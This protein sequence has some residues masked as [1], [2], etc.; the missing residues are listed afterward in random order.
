MILLAPRQRRSSMSTAYECDVLIAGAGPAGLATALR[1]LRLRPHLA[2]RIVALERR[3]H[4]RPKVCAGGLI[5]RAMLA[6]DELG[7]RLDVPA[8]EVR[9]GVARTPSG[10]FA[11][12]RPDA[13][14]TIVRREEF[15]AQ[16]AQ[17]A[18]GAGLEMIED[19]HVLNVRQ[20][21]EAV[22][23]A[24]TRGMFR[25]RFLVGADGSGSRVRR[26]VF[27]ERKA[28][29]GR[30]LMADFPVDAA[31][32]PEFRNAYF[33]FDFTCV[34]DGIHG[35]AWSFP[36]LIAGRPHINIGIYDQHPDHGG[37]GAFATRMRREIRAKPPL[38]DALR[39][40]FTH[41]APETSTAKSFKAFPIRWFE[42]GDRFR[43]G[44]VILAGDAA[45]V[46]P[47]MGEGISC[48]LEHG[49]LAARA[50]A[51]A[52]DG[53]DSALAGYDRELRVG[54]LGRKLRRLGFAARHLYGPRHRLYFRIAQISRRAQELAI[55][56][57]NGAARI[58]E[59][60]IARALSRLGR[61][62]LFDTP[63]R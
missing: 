39:A 51:G 61:A 47:L 31:K 52:L 40:A 7:I 32:V 3:R 63:V 4:P 25:A 42:A 34:S 29:I 50:I 28:T 57:Y 1:L 5:P 35:Y 55:D 60:S 8:V 27:G 20:D 56:W 12:G 45:G 22:E 58:D 54:T 59:L 17:A 48:A 30:A 15:D 46:D 26:A 9:S 43:Q 10:V 41:P 24:S 49:A 11:I 44:R 14:C 38:A 18:R 16:I 36:C 62:V 37:D 6:L 13:M 33:R 21:D 23:V 2:G 53:D 19:C